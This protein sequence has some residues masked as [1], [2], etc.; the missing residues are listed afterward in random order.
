MK[1]PD[2]SRSMSFGRALTVLEPNVAA[3]AEFPKALF[4]R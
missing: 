1:M 2:G 4:V 3:P